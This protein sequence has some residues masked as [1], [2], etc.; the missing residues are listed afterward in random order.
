M[1]DNLRI[2][3]CTT[4]NFQMFIRFFLAE[5]THP[6]FT[7]YINKF[8]TVLDK[9]QVFWVVLDCHIKIFYILIFL[10]KK[11]TDSLLHLILVHIRIENK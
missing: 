11:H 4:F 7:I 1:L 2:K 5:R 9:M 8:S 3:G 6:K 10:R